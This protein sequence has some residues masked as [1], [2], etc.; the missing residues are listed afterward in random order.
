MGNRDF[1]SIYRDK[2]LI[3]QFHTVKARLTR[4]LMVDLGPFLLI[5]GFMAPKEEE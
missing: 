2:Q 1:R 4:R 5:Y 3:L